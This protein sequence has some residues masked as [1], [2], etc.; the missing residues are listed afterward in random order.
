MTD[1]RMDLLIRRIDVGAEPDRQFV[2]TSLARLLP[3]ARDARRF[4]ASPIGRMAA[5]VPWGRPAPVSRRRPV[6]LL[7]MVALA[8]ALLLATL[9]L[10]VV[11]SGL[12]RV[13]DV[14]PSITYSG[15]FEPADLG[16]AP[17]VNGVAIGGGRV[18]FL[19]DPNPTRTVRVWDPATGKSASK[20]A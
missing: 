18:L 4:D 17:P 13:R 7:V 10:A 5:A 1:D 2:E 14:A 9:G 6:P 16:S 12:L 15:S 19:G 20:V 3:A 8:A 11:G